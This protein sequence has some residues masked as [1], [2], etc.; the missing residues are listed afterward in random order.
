MPGLETILVQHFMLFTLVLARIGGLISMAPVF[1][2][3]SI[4]M[5][6][7]GFFAV[8]LSFLITPLF[9]NQQVLAINNMVEYGHLMVN[10]VLVGLLIGLG[11][12]ILFGGI[13]LTGQIISQ[14]SGT[15]LAGTYDPSFGASV[16][17]HSQ[18]LYYLTL[19][20]FLSVGGHRMVM[21]ALLDTF[22]W[23]PPG[24]A[25][26]GDTFVEALTTVM[27]KSFSLGVQAAAP[28]MTALLLATIILGLIGRTLPQINVIAVGFSI[29]SLLTL[30][31][32]FVSVGSIAWLF[33]GNVEETLTFLQEAV[34]SHSSVTP[35]L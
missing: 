3:Q 35:G 19:A 17:I 24:K 1:G 15:A 12:Q 28:A 8:A 11:M 25:V 9:L 16:S 20:V 23:V 21:K 29:N 6:I 30:G 5:R 10:E 4:P 34:T 26:L 18:V 14:L 32:M 13:Q 31:V 33:Q 27:S 2:S 7:R 22:F